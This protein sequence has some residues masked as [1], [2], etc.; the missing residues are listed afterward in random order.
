MMMNRPGPVRPTR[1]ARC[2]ILPTEWGSPRL[3]PTS[4]SGMSMPISMAL[5]LAMP[6]MSPARSA[7]S[8]RSRRISPDR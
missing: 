8:I 1:P 2:L 3:K 4:R 5:V 6:R 7:S